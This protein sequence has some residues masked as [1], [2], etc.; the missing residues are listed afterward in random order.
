MSFDFDAAVAAPFRMQ[1][2]LRRLAPGAAQLTPSRPAGRHLAEK[3]AVLKAHPQQALV[4]ADGFDAQPALRAL[5]AEASRRRP[6]ALRVDADGGLLAPLLGWRVSRGE[7][8]ASDRAIAEVGDVL[9]SL[10]P[11]WRVA[12]LLALAFEEDFAIV[13]SASARIPWVAV[14]LPSHWAPESK[15]G[16]HFAEV[17]APVADNAL[18]LAA[19]ERLL[20]LVSGPDRWERFVWTVTRQPTLQA[21]PAHV[22]RLPWPADADADTIAAMAWFRGERQTFIPLPELGQAVFTIHIGVQRLADAVREAGRAAR[23]ADAL[24]TM[25]DAVLA[26]RGL[27]GARD[28]LVAWL[29]SRAATGAATGHVR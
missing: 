1:P 6:E 7:A 22:P 14:C 16:R 27:S 19:G 11:D 8:A 23:L 28:R 25:S 2:G 26:Y 3:L 12:A 18:L 24:S 20:K 13:D 17:H 29:R 9:Q 21:H 4:V 15:A 5:A 10:D